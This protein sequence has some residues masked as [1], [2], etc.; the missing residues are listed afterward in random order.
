MESYATL[1]EL[2]ARLDWAL[3]EDEERVAT[4]ALEDASD[5]ARGYGRDWPS[6]TVPRL[7][8]TLVLKAA[9]R[10]VKNPGGY[11]QSRAGDETLAWNDSAGHDAGSVYFTRDEQALIKGLAGKAARVWSVPITAWGGRRNG[12]QRDTTGYV[13][14]EGSS[15]PLPY[16]AGDEPW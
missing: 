9:A 10:H 6:E 8:R 15:E 11:T 7:V 13:P 3:D 14:V 12:P 4:S 5:L 1:D 16:F 2:K